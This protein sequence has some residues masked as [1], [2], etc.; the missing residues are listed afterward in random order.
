MLFDPDVEF[1]R[2]VTGGD[3]PLWERMRE[4]RGDGEVR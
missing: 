3:V 1:V 2:E 4:V